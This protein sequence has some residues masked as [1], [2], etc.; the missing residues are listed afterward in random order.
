[1]R[2]VSALVDITNYVMLELGQ[3]LHA[4]DA[5]KIGGN[6][7]I[8]RRARD[9]ERLTTLDGV[10]RQLD[11]SMLV[12][13]DSRQPIAL[14]GVMGG[15][16]SEVSDT[17]TDVLLESA[18]FHNV[19]IRRT[20]ARL[21]MRSEASARFEKNI[22]PEMVPIAS[23]RATRLI[24]ELTG[25]I[26]AEGMIDVYPGQ[27]P[28]PRLTLRESDLRRVLGVSWPA[29]RVAEVFHALGFRDIVC[30]SD[31]VTATAPPWRTDL[32][33]TEDLVEE[34]ARI[35]GYE[36][37]PATPLR[38]PVPATPKDPLLVAADRVRDVLSGA[39]LQEVITYPLISADL[40]AMVGETTVPLAL[41]NPMTTEQAI[42]RTSMRGSILKT[43]ASNARFQDDGVALFEI[44]RVYLP[45][46]GDL[47]DERRMVA[48][49]LH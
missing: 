10:D 23:Q 43:V 26:A 29:S 18:S 2:S 32:R 27:Q 13:A 8:V 25:G 45:R 37:L 11:P 36:E 46:D 17:T 48:G 19:T 22:S 1:M 3:P 6:R 16:D 49:A 30:D 5:A 33:L 4:F 39:G 28:P 7:I 41:V 20:A 31:S 21:R 35:I 44:G 42:L 15:A 47:P 24:V 9:G 38:G 34:V 12:I 40:H 14:A